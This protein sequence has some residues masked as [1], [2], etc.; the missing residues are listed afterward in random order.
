MCQKG[1]GYEIRLL[2]TTITIRKI[3]EYYRNVHKNTN[4]FLHQV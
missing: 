1:L 3:D 2:L 4:V